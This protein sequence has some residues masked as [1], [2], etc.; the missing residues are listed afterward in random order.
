MEVGALE[1]EP[2]EGDVDPR[3]AQAAFELLRRAAYHPGKASGKGGKPGALGRSENWARARGIRAAAA[4]A[5]ALSS[6]SAGSAR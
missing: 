3:Q 4:R 2:A 5:A 1:P 6:A